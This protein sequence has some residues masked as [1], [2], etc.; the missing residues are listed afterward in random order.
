MSWIE[1]CS[2]GRHILTIGQQRDKLKCDLCQK[3]HAQTLKNRLEKE[4]EEK[5]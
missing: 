3:E 1:W 4:K 2:C 5:K